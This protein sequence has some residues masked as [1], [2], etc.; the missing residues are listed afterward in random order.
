MQD[1][2]DPFLA[3]GD[4]AGDDVGVAGEAFG[5]AVDDHV[6]TERERMLKNWAWRR[7]CR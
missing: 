7:C 6:E 3:A 5:G 2:V 1:F 4:G